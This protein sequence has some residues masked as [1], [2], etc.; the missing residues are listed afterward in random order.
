MKNKGIEKIVI[1]TGYKNEY[2]ENYYSSNNS[3]ILTKNDRYKWTGTMYSLAKV[4]NI[5]DD[6]FILLENDMI[7]EERA[8][9]QI[10][11]SQDRDCMLITSESGSGDE[12]LVEIR[13]GYVYKMSKDIH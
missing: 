7:F 6:D 3:I 5:I 2:F 11:K 8:I 4:K 10:L 13:D 1:V 9:D 12:A